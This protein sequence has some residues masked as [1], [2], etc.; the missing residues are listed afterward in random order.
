MKLLYC[1]ACNDL[2][3][4]Q[5]EWRLCNCRRSAGRY[6][7]AARAIVAGEPAFAVGIMGDAITRAISDVA[8]A[9]GRFGP[10]FSGWV[11]P[12]DFEKVTRVA[13]VPSDARAIGRGPS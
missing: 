1:K 13:E 5:R 6:E 2:V 3:R 4:L 7:D 8:T 9:S 12:L 10:A 11:F